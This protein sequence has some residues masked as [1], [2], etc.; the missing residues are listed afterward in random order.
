MDTESINGITIK[1][2]FRKEETNFTIFVFKYPF[3]LTSKQKVTS[4]VPHF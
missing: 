2:I 1:E 4:S 3:P